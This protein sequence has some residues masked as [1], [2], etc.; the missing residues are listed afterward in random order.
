MEKA[1]EMYQREDWD[2]YLFLGGL[3]SVQFGGEGRVSGKGVGM[4]IMRQS[5]PAAA[6]A[7]TA[8]W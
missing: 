1:L 4:E 5:P 7:A 3:V 8:M 6:V 2:V